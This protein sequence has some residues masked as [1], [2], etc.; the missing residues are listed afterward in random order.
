[1][2]CKPTFV[3]IEY[4]TGNVSPIVVYKISVPGCKTMCFI[5]AVAYDDNSIHTSMDGSL[6]FR[7]SFYLVKSSL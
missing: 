6:Y 5:E 3:T 2:F 7:L 1:M 4:M